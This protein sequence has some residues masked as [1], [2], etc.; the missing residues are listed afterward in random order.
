MRSHLAILGNVGLALLTSLPLVGLGQE[1]SELKKVQPETQ[2]PAKAPKSAT[3]AIDDI[4]KLVVFFH[5]EFQQNRQTRSLD[6][7][8]FFVLVPDPRLKDRG[9]VWLVTNKHMIRPPIGPYFDK[10]GLRVNAKAILPDGNMFMEGVLPVMDAAGNLYWCIDPDDES[11]DLALIQV[12]PDESKMDATWFPTHLFST[13]KIFKELMISENDEVL[14]TGLFAAYHGVKRN[15]PIVRHGKLALV[16]DERIP[17]DSRNPSLTEELI[18]AEVTSF[19]GNS[20]SPVF[21]RVGGV[22][23]AGQ[24]SIAPYTYYLLGVM[25]GFFSEGTDLTLDVTAIHGVVSQNSGIAAVIPAEKILHILDLPRAQAIHKRVVAITLS[26]EGR[27]V[28]AGE[29]FRESLAQS[30]KT[31]GMEHPDV[32]STLETY[33]GF[34]NKIGDTAQAKRLEARAKAIRDKANQP[35]QPN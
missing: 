34:L 17:I 29:L 15:F 9:V 7:T 22:R 31:M 24:F 35:H 28:E 16:T 19:G 18:L 32:A 26:N 4:K 3:L 25:Q 6:G 20:G 27:T 10:V 12:S 21:L 23:E 14:F 5:T 8:G 33:A 11:V 2:E 1:Q 30:E 13:K